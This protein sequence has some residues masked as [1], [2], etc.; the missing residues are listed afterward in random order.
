MIGDIHSAL[1][2]PTIFSSFLQF[3]EFSTITAT[4]TLARYRVSLASP[5]TPNQ[6]PRDYLAAIFLSV[7]FTTTVAS[8]DATG[9]GVFTTSFHRRRH[10]LRPFPVS[11]IPTGRFDHPRPP[12]QSRFLPAMPEH[13]WRFCL[14]LCHFLASQW[15]DS[16]YRHH[17][18]LLLD[19]PC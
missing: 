14:L 10:C 3:L 8:A 2:S 19:T 11:A 4:S 1:S 5:R 17:Q 9:D 18:H 15:P 7:P 13:L 16:P 6:H 12:L